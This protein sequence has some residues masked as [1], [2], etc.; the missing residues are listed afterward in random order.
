[1]YINPIYRKPVI[2]NEIPINSQ[3]PF[4]AEKIGLPYVCNY[5]D[6]NIEELKKCINMALHSSITSKIPKEL[7][8]NVYLSR[9]KNIFS[10]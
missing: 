6:N 7:T 8:L 2:V 1:M 10:L 5:K 4:A 9:V 3:H